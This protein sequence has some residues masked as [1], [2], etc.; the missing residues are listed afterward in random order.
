MR[1]KHECEK[2]II[3]ERCLGLALKGHYT[4]IQYSRPVVD[5]TTGATKMIS[6]MNLCNDCFNDYKNLI[7]S[8]IGRSFK[9]N[10]D[11]RTN[12]E[13]LKQLREQMLNNIEE[14]KTKT[15]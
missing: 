9:E 5:D 11:S 7:E 15:R 2:G 8:F 3:C 1:E 13:S 6:K 12:L 10:V 14:V 4:R